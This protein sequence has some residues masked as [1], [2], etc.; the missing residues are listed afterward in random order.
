MKHETPFNG[1]LLTKIIST[2]ETK[3]GCIIHK[4]EY[5]ADGARTLLRDAFGFIYEI[6]VK[7]VSRTGTPVPMFQDGKPLLERVK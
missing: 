5:T 1:W 6:Q 7:T 3:E 2:L 4:S